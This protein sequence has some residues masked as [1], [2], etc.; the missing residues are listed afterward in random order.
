MIDDSKFG[1]QI[2]DEEDNNAVADMSEDQR[3][4]IIQNSAIATANMKEKTA[5]KAATAAA[6]RSTAMVQ[7]ITANYSSSSNSEDEVSERR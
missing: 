5:A 6:A 4:K 2:I 3:K 1:V 7:S